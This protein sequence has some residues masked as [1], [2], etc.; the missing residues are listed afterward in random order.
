MSVIDNRKKDAKHHGESAATAAHILRLM[1]APGSESRA[2][3][4]GRGQHQGE[5]WG[6]KHLSALVERKRDAR[7]RG[8]RVAEGSSSSSSGTHSVWWVLQALNDLLK[9]LR[10]GQ[11]HLGKEAPI[12]T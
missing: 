8:Q 3:A 7:H 9:H 10:N 4:P 12:N 2:E 1:G 11:H 5:A 6:R